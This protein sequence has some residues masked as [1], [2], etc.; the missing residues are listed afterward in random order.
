MESK[1][2]TRI[3]RFDLAKSTPKFEAQ[4][5]EDSNLRQRINV[6]ATL[7]TAFLQAVE[8]LQSAVT[9]TATN[10]PRTARAF[11]SCAAMQ[12]DNPIDFYK[13]VERY[14]ID[15]IKKTLRHTAGNQRRAAKL[16]DLNATTLN[17]KLKNYGIIDWDWLRSGRTF[18]VRHPTTRARNDPQGAQAL[19]TGA[20]RKA[21]S[22]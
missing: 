9:K 10:R 15:L 8:D 3:R 5:E 18:G 2:S 4:T 20:R 1:M 14:E 7:A 12:C 13:E 17:A 22:S 19:T 16:L 21:P 11:G 6:L